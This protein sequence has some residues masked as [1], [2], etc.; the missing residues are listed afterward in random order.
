MVTSYLPSP[1]RLD[2]VLR[3]HPDTPFAVAKAQSIPRTPAQVVP[4]CSGVLTPSK[5]NIISVPYRFDIYGKR[6]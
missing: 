2:G 5:D 1:V 4:P 6:L 3:R